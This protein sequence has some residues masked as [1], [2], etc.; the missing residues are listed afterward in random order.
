[1]KANKY[2]AYA[3][4]KRTIESCRTLAHLKATEEMYKNFRRLYDDEFLRDEIYYLLQSKIDAYL[5]DNPK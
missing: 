2:D 3:K 4:V 5:R 1:M